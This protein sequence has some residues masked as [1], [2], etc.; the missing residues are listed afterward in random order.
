MKPQAITNNRGEF[1]RLGEGLYQYSHTKEFYARFR[2]K[3]ERI[4]QKL[5]STEHPCTDMAEA[6]RRLRD[7]KNTL[8][9]TDSRKSNKTFGEVIAEY[10]AVMH[11]AD[12][13]LIYKKLHLERLRTEFPRRPITKTRDIQKSDV[14][15]FL[16]QYNHLSHSSWNAI[17][18]LTRNVFEH[19]VDDGVIAHSPAASIT[20]RKREDKIKRL[21]P[22]WG[23]FES[24][25]THVRTQKYADTAKESADLIEF[26]GVAGLGQ[27]ECAGLT[28]GDVNFKTEKITIIRKKTAKEFSIP[29]Y[30][31]LLPLLQRMDSEREDKNA[32]A[33][34]F[35]VKDPKVA[36]EAA[37]KRM[38][39]PKYSARAFRRMFITRAL[40]LGIDA[41]TIAQWQGHKDGGQLILRVYARVSDEHTKKMAAKMSAPVTPENI[42]P[43]VT[44]R[45]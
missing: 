5:G 3:G 40:E 35:S 18:T 30:P 42:I 11:F 28:W 8:D 19:A 15:K 31:T 44:T 7:L 2:H 20:Y 37:C 27:A 14:V 13:T 17:L 43:K 39:L 25:V 45:A 16:A 32:T 10:E 23:E 38:K 26:M 12:K 41:Q 6:R 9:H 21:I 33:K 1:K 36:L 34:V 24:I 4:M 22:S 29:I